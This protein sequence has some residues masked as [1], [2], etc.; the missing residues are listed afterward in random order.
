MQP[1]DTG[2]RPKEFVTST[3]F[4]RQRPSDSG[5][6]T[7]VASRYEGE[8]RPRPSRWTI[9]PKESTYSPRV[10]RAEM[11]RRGLDDTRE[12]I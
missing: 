9:Q 12:R 2:A 3:P 10:T 1:K 11:T 7:A 4:V 5:V 6:G 8:E